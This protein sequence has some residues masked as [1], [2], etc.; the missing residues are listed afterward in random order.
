[1]EHNLI[2]RL[3][4]PVWSFGLPLKTF[5]LFWKF[6]GQANQDSLTIYSPTE[7]SGLF[8]YFLFFIFFVNSKHSKCQ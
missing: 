3:D 1:M 2:F 4:I 6:F 8:F 5:R 7:I